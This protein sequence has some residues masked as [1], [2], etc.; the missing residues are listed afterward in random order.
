MAREIRPTYLL[1]DEAAARQKAHELGLPV[2]GSVGT[3]MQ[4]KAAGLIPTVKPLLDAMIREAGFWINS[5][6]YRQVLTQ[7]G[8]EDV[9]A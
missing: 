4:A 5:S 2:I 1:V 9:N 6:F 7:V 8:E 3:L